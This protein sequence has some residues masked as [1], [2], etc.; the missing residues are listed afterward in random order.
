MLMRTRL[1]LS[2]L[3]FFQFF[4]L[5]AWYVPM[6]TY[7]SQTLGFSGSQIGLIAGTNAIGALLSPFLAGLLADRYFATERMLAFLY[8][9]SGVFFLLASFQSSFHGFI[10]LIFGANLCV[11]P[12]AALSTALS[13]KQLDDPQHQ[14]PPI[15]VWGTIGW[16]VAGLIVGGMRW[17]P[18]AFPLRLSATGA[19]YIALQSLFLP[20]TPPNRTPG[21]I[22]LSHIIGIEALRIFRRRDLLVYII[23][24]VL[25]STPVA[26]YYGFTNLF[27]STQGVGRPSAVMTL[28]QA[29]EIGFMLSL[30]WFLRSWG[31]KKVILIGLVA[32]TL[33]YLCFGFGNTNEPLGYSL[34]LLGVMFHGVCFNFF[35][36]SGQIYV[37]QRAPRHLRASA[38]GLVSQLHSGLGVLIGSLFA[39]QVV[40]HFTNTANTRFSTYSWTAIWL[41]PASIGA[42][43]FLIFFFGFREMHPHTQE[44]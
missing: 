1:Q 5:G 2:Q 40:E 7:A 12:T 41:I 9:L 8:G 11:L 15:R 42:L 38:Q 3:M 4:T 28:G 43:G 23:T 33:R 24:I 34:L 25:I 37:D 16:I 20:H 6:S 17:E 32:W 18:T 10:A 26:F 21:P 27:L 22:R 31:F 35:I 44:K 30:S 36:L 29:T 14:F 39:G 13:L 19:F